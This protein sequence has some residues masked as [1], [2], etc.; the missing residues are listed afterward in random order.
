MSNR[1]V[2]IEADVKVNEK[3]IRQQF[4]TVSKTIENLK[5]QVRDINNSP[6]GG[7]DV[8]QKLIDSMKKAISEM[9]V[10]KQQYQNVLQGIESHKISSK[11]LND[12]VKVFEERF[13]VIENRMASVEEMG[14]KLTKSMKAFSLDKLNERIKIIEETV[15]KFTTT[16]GGAVNALS[17]FNQMVDV[18]TSKPKE[19]TIKAD[20]SQLKRVEELLN[21]MQDSDNILGGKSGLKINTA[22]AIKN[23]SDLYSKYQILSD[24]LNKQKDPQELTNIKIRMAELISQMGSFIN[25]ILEL[26]K[27][28]GDDISGGAIEKLGFDINGIDF[29]DFYIN[30]ENLVGKTSTIL[31]SLRDNIKDNMEIAV[32]EATTEVSQFT[33]K[34][35]G[36]RIPVTV[37]AKSKHALE[38]KYNEIV[39][40][41]QEYANVH[42]VNVT[43][44]LFPLNTN[45]ADATEITNELRRIQTD[46]SSVTDEELRTKLNSLYDDLESQFQ[47]ALNLKIKVDLGDTEAS[48]RQRIKELNETV[49]GEGFTIYPKFE[50]PDEEADKISSKLAEIQKDFTFSATSEI[51]TMADSLNKLF[52]IENVEAWKSAFVNALDEINGKLTSF[53]NMINPLLESIKYTSAKNKSATP[54]IGDVNVIIE[55]TNAM[56]ALQNALKKQQEYKLDIDISPVSEKLDI[57]KATIQMISGKLSILPTL[58]NELKSFKNIDADSLI[59][60]I[61]NSVSS[62]SPVLIPITPDL[63]NIEDFVE[64]IRVAL[65]DSKLNIGINNIRL[66]QSKQTSLKDQLQNADYANL[67]YHQIDS[68]LEESSGNIGEKLRKKISESLVAGLRNG[69]TSVSEMIDVGLK[70]TQFESITQQIIGDSDTID[71]IKNIANEV[72]ISFKKTLGDD[73]SDIKMLLN[74]IESDIQSSGKEITIPISPSQNNVNQFVDKVQSMIDSRSVHLKISD[75][76]INQNNLPSDNTIFNETPVSTESTNVE[77]KALLSKKDVVEQLRAELNLTKKAA[78]DLFNQQGYTKTNNKYQIEQIAVNELIASL[79]EKKQIE[80]SQNPSTTS[81]TINAM[82]SEVEA[83]NQ[84]VDTEKKKFDELKNKISKTIPKAIETKNKSFE[85]EGNLVAKIVDDEITYF[86]VLKDTVDGVTESISKQENVAKDLKQKNETQKQKKQDKP[87]SDRDK[88]TLLQEHYTDLRRSAYQS[89]GQKSDIQQEMSKYYSQIA[90]ESEIAYSKAENKANSLI[91]QVD[92]IKRFG[93]YTSDFVAELDSA[94]NELD[95]FLEELRSG[96]IPFETIDQRIKTLSQDIEGTLSKKAFSSVKQ[97]AEKSLTNVGLKIDQ[98]I[99]KNSAMGKDFESRFK[100]LRS[101]LGLAE[102]VEDVQRIIAEVNKLESELISTGN[103]GKSFIDQIKQRMRDIN[104]KY[105]AQYFSFQDIIRYARQAV[106][107]VIELNDAFIELS[108][109]SNTTVKNLEADFQSYADIAKD[110]GGTITDTINATAD[111][112]RMGYSVPDSKQLAEVAMLY[113]NVGDGIDITA[114]N[115]SL[116]STLQGFQMQADEAEHIVDVFNEVAN[117]YAIG[118]GGIGEALQRSAASLNAANTSLEESVALVTAANTVVQNPESVGTTFKTLSARIRGADTELQELGEDADEF[119]ETTSKLQGLVKSLTG[120]DILEADQKTY[121]SIYEILIGIGKEWQNLSD[122][123]RASLGEALAGKFYYQD[124]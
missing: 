121:K 16:I 19:I 100:N 70:G 78:E 92:N 48:L 88:A 123:E 14:S 106:T 28:S 39:N 98:I 62:E 21:K 18:S 115:E 111:W 30:I 36:I 4:Q 85:K 33:F 64:Q 71:T 55:F 3:K 54:N 27:I 56:S 5:G 114:A 108:K 90:K 101:D 94:R 82:Q 58:L 105:I 75:E 2:T 38:T 112:A 120:F 68:K 46:I 116:I 7:S 25:R 43:M 15:N 8:A 103:T 96:D 87:T 66:N 93:K 44:R 29:A 6:K 45:R 9:E 49:R 74:R 104:T 17:T 63:S 12:F 22:T 65:S 95:A 76:S 32:N 91:V 57:L 26:K 107:N 110:I 24:E 31:S 67:L 60:N 40:T 73:N 72:A 122:I 97:A 34:N 83:V 80:A 69:L 86:E 117:N 118:S 35:G 1:K 41:L 119:T 47:K 23:L 89:F 84:A 42:P 59:Q 10:M 109:V 99:A 37:D 51:K 11:Q 61:Q 52:S 113:K 79:K 53:H 20:T 13:Q 102:S 50:I 124:M 77:T 81:P